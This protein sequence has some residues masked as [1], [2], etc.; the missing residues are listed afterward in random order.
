MFKS[1]F[2]HRYVL[3]SIGLVFLYSCQEN[4]SIEEIVRPVRTA[5]IFSSGGARVRTFSGLVKSG[6]ESRLSFKVSGTVQN[7]TVEI[8]SKVRAGDI[9]ISL[10]PTDYDIQLKQAENQRDLARASEVQ[11]KAS[12]ERVRSSLRKPQRIQERT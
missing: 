5:Q 10:D 11:T 9:L 3:I 7:I 2:R 4:E 6:S 1:I 12:Y 8:G